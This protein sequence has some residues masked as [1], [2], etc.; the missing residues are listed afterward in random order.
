MVDPEYTWKHPHM[1]MADNDMK[2]LLAVDPGLNG[3]GWAM[4]DASVNKDRPVRT[5][6]I[7]PPR[8]ATLGVRMQ[9]I[10]EHLNVAAEERIRIPRTDDESIADAWYTHLVVEMPAFQS[11]ATRSMGWQTGDLQKLTLL[12]GYLVHD[13]WSRV[14]LITPAQWKGQLPKAVV[15]RRIE[16]RLGPKACDRLGI[17]THAWDAVGIGMHIRGEM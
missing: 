14:T 15:Q 3:T 1:D 4:W 9:V 6:V 12:V 11:G 10:L 2:R 8:N 7:M 13:H 5:G 16:K 17:K